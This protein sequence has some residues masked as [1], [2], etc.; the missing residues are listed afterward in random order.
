[1]DVTSRFL[2]GLDDVVPLFGHVL[3]EQFLGCVSVAYLDVEMGDRTVASVTTKAALLAH[4]AM[5]WSSI[6]IFLTLDTVSVSFLV[7]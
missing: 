6:I 5:S 4:T 7:K 3:D 2:L 1:M